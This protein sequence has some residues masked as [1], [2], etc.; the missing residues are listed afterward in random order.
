MYRVH[1]LRSCVAGEGVRIGSPKGLISG[2]RV[3]I[4]AELRFW[5]IVDASVVDKG[6]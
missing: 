2:D 4:A 6:Y 3:Q 1:H 5:Q